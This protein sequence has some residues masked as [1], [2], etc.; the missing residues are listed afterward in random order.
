[1]CAVL[2]FI[3]GE[4]YSSVNELRWVVYFCFKMDQ[5]L[6]INE[7]FA[8]KYNKYREKEELQKC[9]SD[10]FMRIDK[11]ERRKRVYFRDFVCSTAPS[12][13]LNDRDV[14]EPCGCCF[15]DITP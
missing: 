15:R 4:E 13:C 9:K 10:S 11:E 12:R 14:K 3:F 6:K 5:K 8:K 7:E 1:M 2:S